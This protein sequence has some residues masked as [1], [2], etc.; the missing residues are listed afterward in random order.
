VDR[1]GK[2]AA[3]DTTGVRK[4]VRAMFAHKDALALYKAF[5]DDP[6]RRGLFRPLGRKKIEYA[7]VFPLIHTMI[8]TSRQESFS[9]IRHLLVDEM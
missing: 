1:G 6:S 9:H 7:D 8:R 2:W 5:Y 3:S 4:Q